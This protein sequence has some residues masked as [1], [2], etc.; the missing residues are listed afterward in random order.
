M[1]VSLYLLE[2]KIHVGYHAE[3]EM[4]INILKA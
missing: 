3:G 1:F 2:V 4:Q